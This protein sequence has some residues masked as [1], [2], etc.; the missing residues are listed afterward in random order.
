ML[1]AKT[2]NKRMGWNV[3]KDV[4]H[5]SP[6]SGAD[7]EPLIQLIQPIDSAG[8][9]DGSQ[10]RIGDRI[11]PKSLRVTGVLSFNKDSGPSNIPVYVRVIIAAQ[12]DIKNGNS[13]LNGNVATSALLH[14]GILGADETAFNGNTVDITYPINK[15]KFRVYMDKT[16]ML[17][18][19]NWGGAPS[20]VEELP[21]YQKRWSYTFKSSQLPASLTF[22]SAAGNWPNNFAPFVAIGYAYSNGTGPDSAQQKIY[23]NVTSILDFED[24]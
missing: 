19:G 5:N 22:D 3:E 21:H 1:A 7:C 12:K 24:P 8:G 11:N 9:S 16:F 20:T 14:P 23:S 10:Q 6:I 18:S 15:N 2:E 13:V 17:C 4:L